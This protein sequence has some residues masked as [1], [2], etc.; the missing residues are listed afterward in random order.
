MKKSLIIGMSIKAIIGSLCLITLCNCGGSSNDSK[1]ECI[2]KTDVEECGKTVDQ[3]LNIS[4]YLDLSDRLIRELTPSQMER[5]TAI[6]NH[7]VDVFIQDCIAHKIIDSK[8]HFQIFFYPTP[9]NSEI[10]QLAKGLNVDMA[11]IAIKQKKFELTEMKS[12]FQDNLSQIYNDAIAQK[13]WVGCD[14]WGFFS[15][16][17]VDT[18]CVRDGYRNI[19]VILTD[20]YLFHEA[21]KVVDGKA[22]S[23]VLPQTLEVEGSSLI[24][25][26][27]GL[28]NLEV[29]MLEVNPYTPQQH[30]A[31]I[32]ILENWFREM[33][34][35]KLVVSETDLP[36]NTEVYID[37][38]IN[39]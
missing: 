32:T 28:T 30:N 11:K 36:V 8:S 1:S 2:T 18:L 38:F 6:I 4:V 10:A 19:L 3:P 12:R 33:G 20:G 26:R 5:D 31:L 22:Y 13:K 37:S 35:E 24:T 9:N 34:V 15:N 23:Y 14:I 27:N 39:D 17:V 25:K 7:L 21:N 29:L 16:K